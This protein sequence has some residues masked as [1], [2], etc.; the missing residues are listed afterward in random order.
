VTSGPDKEWDVTKSELLAA[1]AGEAGVDQATAERVIGALFETVTS[2]V[3]QEDKVTW[4]GFGSFSGSTRPARQGRNP[5]T[6]A[7]IQIAASR[8][9]KFSPASGLKSALN[10]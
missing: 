8:V 1:V 3:K 4:P 2:V 9:A 5:S 7:T 6:G 10:G